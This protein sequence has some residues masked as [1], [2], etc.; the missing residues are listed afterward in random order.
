MPNFFKRILQFKICKAEVNYKALNPRNWKRPSFKKIIRFLIILAIFLAA[1]ITLKDEYEYQFGGY[2]GDDY[3]YTEDDGLTC[4]VSGIELHGD[5]VTY[6]I[7]ENEDSDGR[8][9]TDEVSSESIIS[10]LMEAQADDDIKAVIL[11]IDSYGG[12][13]VAAYEI[14]QALH[15]EITKPVI[16]MVRSAATSGAYLAAVGADAIFASPYSDIG[17]IGITMSYVDYAQQNAKEGLTYNSLTAGKY[18]DYGN[19]DKTLTEEEKALMM[20]DLNIMHEGIIQVI[21]SDRNLD[22]NKVRVLADGSSMPGQMA[23]DNGLID[24]IGGITEVEKYL[25]DKIGEDAIACW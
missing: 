2:Y 16:V 5:I 11:E 17:G 1:C 23:K 15:K 7:P 18:K 20:R 24:E 19:P 25:K 14:N 12:S 10:A 22:V 4:N 8:S 3:S 21:A 13:P 9:L 6:I